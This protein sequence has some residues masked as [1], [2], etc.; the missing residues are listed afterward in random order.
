MML[1]ATFALVLAT[2]A[3]AATKEKERAKP[4]QPAKTYTNEDLRTAKGNVTVLEVEATSDTSAQGETSASSASGGEREPSEA[5]KREKL[6]GELQARIDEERELIA[7]RLMDM[8]RAQQEL[9]DVSG[10]V[11]S[12]AGPDGKP[13]G[14]R[15]A[16]QEL[17]V[18]AEKQIQKAQETIA[19]LEEQARRQGIRVQVP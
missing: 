4:G 12:I 1:L 14:H 2:A 18:E 16:L 6:A 17:V 5:E 3:P 15:A 11:F 7:V 9:G 10:Q 8:Q 13:T 19:S